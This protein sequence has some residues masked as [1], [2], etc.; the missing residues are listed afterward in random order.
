MAPAHPQQAHLAPAVQAM[1]SPGHSIPPSPQYATHAYAAQQYTP[2]PTAV[3]HHAQQPAHIAPGYD[4]QRMVPAPAMTPARPA[5]AA[6]PNTAAMPHAGS[7][8]NVYNPPRAPEVYTIAPNVNDAIPAE[9]RELYDRD[10]HGRI[11]FFTAPPVPRAGNGLAP[12][13]AGLGHS[14]RYLGDF[15]Q[16][17][18]ERRRKRKERDEALAE[19]AK[20]KATAEALNK[21]KADEAD[22]ARGRQLFED[23]VG[24]LAAGNKLVYASLDG[25]NRERPEE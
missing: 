11:L 2:S 13:Y 5:M 3:A 1:Q 9:T 8:A 22:K 24:N 4:H 6:T 7:G 16:H 12:E 23:L 21:A 20:K 25:W 15:K 19:E 10:E 17:V 18:E 14:T